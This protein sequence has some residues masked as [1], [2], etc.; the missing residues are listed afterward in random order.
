MDAGENFGGDKNAHYSFAEP[1]LTNCL[2][3][4]TNNPK[5]KHKRFTVA[6]FTVK[7]FDKVEPAF[8]ILLDIHLKQSID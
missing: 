4:P 7:T 3:L 1:T 5:Q 6:L 2:C 8:C